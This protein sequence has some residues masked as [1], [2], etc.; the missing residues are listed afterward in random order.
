MKQ[1]FTLI[2][3]LVVI[4]IIAILAAMLMPALQQAREKARDINCI[5]NEKQLGTAF[6]MYM[7]QSDGYFPYTAG[8]AASESA[9][10]ILL[11]IR[12]E[13][14]GY[15]QKG[16]GYINHKMLD[17]PSDPTRVAGVDFGKYDWMKEHNGKYANRSYVIDTYTG[18]Q[19]SGVTYGP[20]KQG[21]VKSPTKT[22]AAFCSDPCYPNPATAKPNCW[23][24]GDCQYEHH[25]EPDFQ[26][27]ALIPTF[28]RHGMKLNVVTLDGR[29]QAYM[30]TT[31]QT[32]NAAM[33]NYH[34][35]NR[36][37]ARL[38]TVRWMKDER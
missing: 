8:L 25:I 22:V 12:K 4:A 38:G 36:P 13:S 29:A 27:G 6:T 18:S 1:K 5:S 19:M 7:D 28:A 30:V 15:V 21:M 23:T 26:G 37:N 11:G 24:R 31:D 20:Y 3:L 10:M 16:T 17:C 9:W 32:A 14:S 33:L 34:S 2:E 35:V